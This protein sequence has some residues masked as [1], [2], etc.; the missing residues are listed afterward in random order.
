[1]RL[2]HR[3]LLLH[4]LSDRLWSLLRSICMLY[5]W[6]TVLSGGL[7]LWCLL[8]SVNLLRLVLLSGCLWCVWW[9]EELDIVNDHFKL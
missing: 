1:M 3:H 4:R 7:R 2:L 5:N 9:F 8:C 6:L